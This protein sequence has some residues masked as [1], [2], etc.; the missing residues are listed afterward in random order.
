MRRENCDMTANCGLR[1]PHET[2][3][4]RAYDLITELPAHRAAPWHLSI[5]RVEALGEPAVD[6]ARIA[7][8]HM[9]TSAILSG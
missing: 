5:A 9:L 6:G 3:T 2:T 4:E 7:G 1:S 8:L